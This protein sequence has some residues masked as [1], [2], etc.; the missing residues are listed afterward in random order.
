M[1]HATVPGA[2]GARGRSARVD[3][4]ATLAKALRWAALAFGITFLVVG[5]AGFILGGGTAV[6]W[7][8]CVL[9]SDG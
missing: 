1:T 9:V 4:D 8:S 7:A 5:I 6:G 3:D 2:A